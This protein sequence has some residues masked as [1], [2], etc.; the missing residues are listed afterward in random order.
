MTSFH[1]LEGIFL[2]HEFSKT[3]PHPLAD[4]S[5]KVTVSI[6]KEAVPSKGFPVLY[7]LDG[8]AY[9]LLLK[10]MIQLQWRRSEKTKVCPMVIVSIGYDINEV[11][12]PLRV[13]DFTPPTSSISLPPK[14]D[15]SEWPAYGGAERFLQLITRDIQPFVYEHA[16]VHRERQTLFGHSLGGLFVLYTLFQRRNLFQHY[17]SCSPSIWWNECQILTYEQATCLLPNKKLFI[18]AEKVQKMRMYD[19]AFALYKRLKVLQPDQV[20]FRSPTNENHMSIV[21][22]ILSDALRFL[23]FG[24]S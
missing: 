15:G 11:F 7:V 13:F 21:P 9:G 2:Q 16:P 23:R 19:H 8:N 5:Y 3:F 1:G 18:A 6:P 14:P 12:S 4:T 22:T 20:A 10:E 17:I 24:E